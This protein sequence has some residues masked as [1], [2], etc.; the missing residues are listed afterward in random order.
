VDYDRELESAVVGDAHVCATVWS[1]R[2]KV[3]SLKLRRIVGTRF[4]MSVARLT[5]GAGDTM[6]AALLACTEGWTD[7]ERTKVGIKLGGAS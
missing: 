2:D 6:A 1:I 7:D 5:K 4:L 3:N